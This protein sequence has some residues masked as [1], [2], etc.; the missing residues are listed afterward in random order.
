MVWQSP[1]RLGKI[2]KG[3]EAVLQLASPQVFPTRCKICKGKKTGI[4]N[5]ERLPKDRKGSKRN[6][7]SCTTTLSTL[8]IWFP[9]AALY[10]SFSIP[11][12]PTPRKQTTYY[13]LH[14][15]G[16]HVFDLPSRDKVN[17]QQAILS[18]LCFHHRNVSVLLQ[19]SMNLFLP[20]RSHKVSNDLLCLHSS[21]HN[22]N[23][24]CN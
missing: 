22:S 20:A 14:H 18:V 1:V 10:S 7:R 3:T 23:L 5:T 21:N 6:M 12:V 4:V 8:I 16:K 19:G 9:G 13:W 11:S 24:E 15:L 17:T 2:P